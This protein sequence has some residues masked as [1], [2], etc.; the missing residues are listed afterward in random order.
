MEI[1]SIAHAPIST[2]FIHSDSTQLPKKH[3]FD[4]RYLLLRGRTFLLMNAAVPLCPE[5]GDAY[6]ISYL[7][8]SFPGLAND[9]NVIGEHLLDNL[10]H[11]RR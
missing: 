9:V 8:Y 5:R 10:S 4:L 2:V 7:P 3:L 11:T 6:R 1:D